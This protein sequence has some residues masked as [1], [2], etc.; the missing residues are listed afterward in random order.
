VAKN[1]MEN[2]SHVMHNVGGCEDVEVNVHV[3]GVR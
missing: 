3:T 1:I 2:V